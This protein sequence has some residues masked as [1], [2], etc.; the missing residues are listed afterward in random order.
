MAGPSSAPGMATPGARPIARVATASVPLQLVRSYDVPTDD[1]SYVQLLNWSW[2][3]DSAMSAMAFVGAGD[4]DE[5]ESV[6]RSG[7]IA[8]VG[9]AGTLYDQRTHST[10]YLAMEQR[11]ANYLLTLQ[12]PT[13]LIR[14]GPDVSWYSTQ[15]NLLGYAFL[16][17]LGN[18]LT[19]QGNRTA[20]ATYDTAAGKVASGIETNLLV[21]KG[22]TAYLF[23]GLGD[24][25]QALDADA[26]GIMYLE[27]RG[28]T[29]LA[30]QVL[31]YTQSAF[32]VTGRSIS[33]SNN[34]ATY[35]MAYSA[36]GPFSGFAP[37]LGSGAPDV[38]WTEGSAEMMA[39]EAGLGQ[40]TTA[41]GQS[42]ASI[43]AV[44]P[45]DAPVQADQTVTNVAYGAEY[46][47]WPSAATGA[48]MM[49]ALLRST[50][51]LFQ[52]LG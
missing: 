41:L 23:E 14:G 10:R 8:A 4:T 11:A 17:L 32:A 46:H 40:S 29:S 39:A 34:P 35:N 26:L 30:Q 24:S 6:F 13:E 19:G 44:T 22:S 45:G 36:K 43:A 31:A 33:L 37:Y 50:L 7:T 51:P 28:E 21:R 15:H 38:L 20:A 25:L 5:A 27:S 9:L 18:E 12:G 42:L 47:V 3:Y 1:P 49:L 16:V 52:P 2:T 48:W